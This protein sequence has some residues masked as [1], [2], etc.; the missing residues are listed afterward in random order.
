MTTKIGDLTVE[1]A[2]NHRASEFSSRAG[3]LAKITRFWPSCRPPWGPHYWAV[4]DSTAAD[5]APANLLRAR[6]NSGQPAD[7]LASCQPIDRDFEETPS[8]RCSSATPRVYR[9]HLHGPLAAF[10]PGR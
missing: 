1:F 3:S 8:R 4:S 10:S 2:E 5:G 6:G 7:P 9:T